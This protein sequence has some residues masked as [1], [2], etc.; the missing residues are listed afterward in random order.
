VEKIQDYDG[1]LVIDNE[2]M[3]LK[4]L[5]IVEF[6]KR[7]EENSLNQYKNEMGERDRRSFP[8][9]SKDYDDVD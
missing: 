6:T 1:I 3:N 2:T 8:I 5:H 9:N 4:K 7:Y